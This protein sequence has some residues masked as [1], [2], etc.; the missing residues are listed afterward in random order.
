MKKKNLVQ[1]EIDFKR[2]HYLLQNGN[3]IV[4]RKIEEIRGINIKRWK[5][6]ITFLNLN[7]HISNEKKKVYYGLIRI[8]KESVTCETR[9]NIKVI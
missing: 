8:E 9:N 6:S 5:S 3:D 4:K 2:I 1:V 7:H